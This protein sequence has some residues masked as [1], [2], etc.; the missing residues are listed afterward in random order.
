[1]YYLSYSLLGW[2][3][4]KYDRRFLQY[5]EL[6]SVDDNLSRLRIGHCCDVLSGVYGNMIWELHRNEVNVND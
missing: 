3:Q 5:R 2:C 1:M 4:F 6:T